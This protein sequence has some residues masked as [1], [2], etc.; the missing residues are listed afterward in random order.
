MYQGIFFFLF[1]NVVLVISSILVLSHHLMIT[2]TKHITAVELCWATPKTQQKH[3]SDKLRQKGNSWLT[4][5]QMGQGSTQ[6]C[7]QNP[8]I[9]RQRWIKLGSWWSGDLQITWCQRDS[10]LAQNSTALRLSGKLSQI[11]WCVC[12]GGGV[13][14]DQRFSKLHS[15][16]R[17]DVMSW[18]ISTWQLFSCRWLCFLLRLRTALSPMY[19]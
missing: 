10:H 8:P 3:T 19:H 7:H 16:L 1:I 9:I 12:V 15:I 6:W 17:M 18:S 14:V 11:G 2:P 13:C 5:L 4:G